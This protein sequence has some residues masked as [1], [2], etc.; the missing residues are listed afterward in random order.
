MLLDSCGCLSMGA[1]LSFRFVLVLDVDFLQGYDYILTFSQEVLLFWRIPW[2]VFDMLFFLNRYMPI[3][4]SSIS[5]YSET[6]CMSNSRLYSHLQRSFRAWGYSRSLLVCVQTCVMYEFLA[7]DMQHHWQS[8]I[9]TW[10]SPPFAYLNVC[11]SG[12]YDLDARL[13]NFF[14]NSHSQNLD[15][16]GEKPQIG[17]ITSSF[18]RAHLGLC[19]CYTQ[20]ARH[21]S[22]WTTCALNVCN[23]LF[24][25][26][27]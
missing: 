1:L 14:S 6:F 9:Q 13:N 19:L 16:L 12:L 24:W 22:R 26:L 3:A 11:L 8:H 23:V 10:S 2:K 4:T 21:S 27:D 15:P 25:L 7:S 5:L 18:L 17:N 20:A